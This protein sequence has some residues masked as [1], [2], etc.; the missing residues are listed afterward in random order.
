MKNL[1]NYG[2]IELRNN[3]TIYTKGGI[4]QACAAYRVY[5]IAKAA[6]EALDYASEHIA[7]G[8]NNPQ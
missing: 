6:F 2:V 7:D 3:E 5:K 1:N 4:A 8:W